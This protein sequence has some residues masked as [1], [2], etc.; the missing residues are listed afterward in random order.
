MLSPAV[1][2]TDCYWGTLDI[3]TYKPGYQREANH[4]QCKATK[5]MFTQTWEREREREYPHTRTH[6]HTHV[7]E[8]YP[9]ARRASGSTGESTTIWVYVV[10]WC[11]SLLLSLQRIYTHTCIDVGKKKEHAFAYQKVCFVNSP[12]KSRTS[13]STISIQPAAV[14]Y[15]NKYSLRKQAIIVHF[16]YRSCTL[17]TCLMMQ[18]FFLNG[19]PL[20]Y[21]VFFQ[22]IWFV[23]TL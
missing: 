11:T 3:S 18:V 10:T 1:A 12:L 22:I 7:S 23:W 15:T 4:W 8:S 2:V 17:L 21:L 5:T 16:Y 6:T 20:S 19:R 14:V 13:I 9:L